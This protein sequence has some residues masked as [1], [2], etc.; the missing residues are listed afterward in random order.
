MMTDRSCT[1]C[2]VSWDPGAFTIPDLS[3]PVCWEYT[4]DGGSWP[5]GRRF[6]TPTRPDAVRGPGGRYYAKDFAIKADK[7]KAK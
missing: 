7:E 2:R 4:W 5:G 1:I 3:C 6:F